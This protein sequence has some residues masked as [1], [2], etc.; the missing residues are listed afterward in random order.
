MADETENC[1][2]CKIVAGTAPA[3]RI[4]EDEQ[5]LAIL[6]INPYA[7]G[8]VLVISKR[9]TQWWHELNA[10]ET[11]SLFKTANL[12]ANKMM[13]AFSPEFVLMFARGRRIPHTHIFLVPTYRGDLLDRFFNA[14]E[15]I[16][17]S[18]QELAR[19]KDAAAM[20]E[21]AQQLRGA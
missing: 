11:A 14:L 10:D 21:A 20:E 17:E 9:H 5:S 6:D 18:P 15:K 1:A 4:H 19:L 3:Y 8:H 7:K 12:V 2:F 16:Q 13:K